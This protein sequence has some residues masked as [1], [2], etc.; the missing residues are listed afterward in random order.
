MLT[1]ASCPHWEFETGVKADMELKC[2][3]IRVRRNRVE[4]CSDEA[5]FDD[6][7]VFHCVLFKRIVCR[8]E[9]LLRIGEDFVERKEENALL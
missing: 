1:M 5:V 4:K 9:K 7:C 2:Q 8:H 3:A 6:L